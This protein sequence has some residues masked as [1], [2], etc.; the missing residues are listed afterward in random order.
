MELSAKNEARGVC[1]LVRSASVFRGRLLSFTWEALPGTRTFSRTSRFTGNPAR[2][3]PSRWDSSVPL[4]L[5]RHPAIR[6]FAPF[7]PY[8]ADDCI[9]AFEKK[10]HP[11]K[12]AGFIKTLSRKARCPSGIS[13][14]RT[15]RLVAVGAGKSSLSLSGWN[16]DHHKDHLLVQAGRHGIERPGSIPSAVKPDS[17]LFHQVQE[18][19]LQPLH[20]LLPGETFFGQ[21]P[22]A[23]TQ[24]TA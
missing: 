8:L 12:H 5:F 3:S 15:A 17:T 22:G 10:P 13:R 18:H 24:P 11:G 4:I 7:C 14:N 20:A 2:F 21:S 16:S 6:L 9:S 23:V 19:P 1:P